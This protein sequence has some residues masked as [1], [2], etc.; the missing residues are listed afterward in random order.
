MI[1]AGI[2]SLS[3]YVFMAITTYM[4]VR[5]WL[6]IPY[7]WGNLAIMFVLTL[8]LTIVFFVIGIQ[9]AWLKLVL[10]GAYML[11]VLFFIYPKKRVTK[12]AA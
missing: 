6:K 1:G 7:E 9:I 12:H 10:V 4:V 11:V 5:N 2:S 8:A 3:A